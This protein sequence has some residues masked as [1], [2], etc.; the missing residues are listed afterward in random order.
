MRRILAISIGMLLLSGG[1]ATAG[2]LGFEDTAEGIAKRL[3][4]PAARPVR[5]LSRPE[6]WV[7]LQGPLA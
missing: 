5:V 3:L 2:D 1:L 7:E 4:K 6:A